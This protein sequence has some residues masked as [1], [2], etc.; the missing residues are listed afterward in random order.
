VPPAPPW[1]PLPVAAPGELERPPVAPAEP[2]VEFSL[3]LRFLEAAKVELRRFLEAAGFDPSGPPG[4]GDKTAKWRGVDLGVVRGSTDVMA[5]AK[6]SVVR[7]HLDHP[8]VQLAMQSFEKDPVVL[9]FVVSAAFTALNLRH[10][11]ITDQEELSFQQRL[12]EL[13]AASGAPVP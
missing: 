11:A 1:T 5:E 13:A 6:G 9:A 10:V 8:A 3:E 2:A 12:A 4:S 7:L